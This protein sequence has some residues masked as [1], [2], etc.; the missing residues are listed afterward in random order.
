MQNSIGNIFFNIETISLWRFFLFFFFG[1]F[2][3]DYIMRREFSSENDI[4]SRKGYHYKQ[5]SKADTR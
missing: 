1:V 2:Q 5:Y 3:Y 4:Y